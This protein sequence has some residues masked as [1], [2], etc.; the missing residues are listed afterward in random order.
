MTTYYVSSAST[1][2]ITFV[3]NRLRFDEDGTVVQKEILKTV[4]QEQIAR[5][6]WQEI[7]NKLKP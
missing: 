3:P 6:I 1:N 7:L 2:D 4:E 5:L